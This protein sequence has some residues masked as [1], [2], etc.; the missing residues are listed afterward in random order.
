V[1]VRSHW[2]QDC[3]A[4]T[5]VKK[6]I[7]NLKSVNPCFLCL[8]R[9]HHTHA[10]SKRSTVF[11]SKCKK[12]HHRSIC[13]DKA[14][15]TRRTSPVTSASVGRVN[16]TSPDFTYL[17]TARVWVTGPMGL[18]K[19]T[20]YVLDDGSQCS[21]FAR[22]VIDDLQLEVIDQRDLSV[23]PFETCP[24]APGRR[25]FVRFNMRTW[26]NALTSLT[27]L[28]STHAFSHHPA[29]SHDIKSLAHARKL[30]LSEP[31]DDSDNPIE[32]LIGGDHYWKIVKDTSPIHLSP[33][34]VLPSSK[35]G[36]ILSGN[37]SAISAS[38]VMVI[39]V[40]L[41]PSPFNADDVVV[42]GN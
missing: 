20:R 3:K 26:A 2:A 27:A 29:F 25:R 42:F 7:E 12:E 32:I 5:D 17:Q 22:S 38:S 16:I 31:P 34:V 14:T 35:L 18:G 4:L 36:S 15:S 21:F 37:R 24:T 1:N 13:M 8:N 30:R 41:D 19:L 23:T 33:S 6:R 10:C 11:C 28:E 39:Y 40:N 9:S